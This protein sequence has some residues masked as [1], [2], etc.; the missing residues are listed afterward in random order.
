MFFKKLGVVLPISLFA[1]R[2]AVWSSAPLRCVRSNAMWLGDLAALAALYKIL[3]IEPQ[4]NRSC[5]FIA[6]CIQA[7][8][9]HSDS[10]PVSLGVFQARIPNRHASATSSANSDSKILEARLQRRGIDP[11]KISIGIVIRNS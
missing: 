7:S 4:P 9:T 6:N 2:N 5:E 1:G 3:G 11:S 8:K 10:S